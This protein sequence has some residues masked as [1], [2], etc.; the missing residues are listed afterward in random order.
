MVFSSHCNYLLRRKQAAFGTALISHLGQ[1]GW[2]Q[3]HLLGFLLLVCHDTQSNETWNNHEN[4][5]PA[6][7][8]AGWGG[9]FLPLGRVWVWSLPKLDFSFLF[10]M[11]PIPAANRH[12]W[13]FYHRG[14]SKAFLL[15]FHL[16]QELKIKSICLSWF[17]GP[18]SHLGHEILCRLQARCAL[19]F[20]GKGFIVDITLVS[21]PAGNLHAWCLD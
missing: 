1:E 12:W 2:L 18:Q 16:C 6:Q 14:R 3:L 10:N 8:R 4:L 9:K 21:Y 5:I 17:H 20:E 11:G 15:N 19:S 13:C 7:Q